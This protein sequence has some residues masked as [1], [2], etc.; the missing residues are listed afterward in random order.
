MSG[1]LPSSARFAIMRG[2]RQ[3]RVLQE[4]G[5]LE[6]DDKVTANTILVALDAK[7]IQLVWKKSQPQKPD[8]LTSNR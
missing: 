4:A 7:G 6:K 1:G 2:L 8:P 3:A 5:K